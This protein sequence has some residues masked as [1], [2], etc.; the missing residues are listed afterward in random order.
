MQIILNIYLSYPK[1]CFGLLLLLFLLSACAQPSSNVTDLAVDQDPIE[2][3][4]QEMD[5][6]RE[7]SGIPG[8][9]VAVLKN[10]Q[11]VYA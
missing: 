1:A 7:N 11:I 6:L 8:M 2:Y 5:R 3:F 4:R 9:A 10:Q